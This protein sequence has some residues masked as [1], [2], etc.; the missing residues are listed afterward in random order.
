MYCAFVANENCLT[1]SYGNIY[2]HPAC[3]QCKLIEGLLDAGLQLLLGHDAL[4]KHIV[5]IVL[6]QCTV[7]SSSSTNRS[8]THHQCVA[9]QTVIN[10][11]EGGVGFGPRYVSGLLYHTITHTEITVY[12]LHTFL[13]AVTSSDST[14]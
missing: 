9:V 14:R 13:L 8:G 11:Q 3:L 7:G 5:I 12:P 6:R 10:V 4:H 2:T 1:I